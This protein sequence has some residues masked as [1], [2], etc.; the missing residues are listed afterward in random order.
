MIINLA[1][2]LAF[3]HE[4]TAYDASYVALAKETE[5]TFITADGMLCER[6]RGLDFVK[7]IGDI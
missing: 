2:T 7:F 1:V 3:E 6:V 4:I 5:L